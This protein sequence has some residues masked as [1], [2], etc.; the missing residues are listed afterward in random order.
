MQIKMALEF[1]LIPVCTAKIKNICGS[2]CWGEW[3]N[4]NFSIAGGSA[5]MLNK[6]ENQL[7]GFSEN[8]D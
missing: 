7:G 1:H 5:N 8:W 3:N 4:L 6:F 2:L